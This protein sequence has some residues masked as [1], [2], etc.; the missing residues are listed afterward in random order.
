MQGSIERV[1]GGGD[2]LELL[3]EELLIEFPEA[4]L[5]CLGVVLHGVPR[6]MLGDA[7]TEGD[8]KKEGQR[9]ALV[10]IATVVVD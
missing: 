7:G 4:G 5:V 1:V 6:I 8:E 3:P 10:L 9:V 2:V